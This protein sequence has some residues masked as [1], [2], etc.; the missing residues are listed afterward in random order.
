MDGACSLPEHAPEPA[1]WTR[2]I[3]VHNILRSVKGCAAC[4]VL[5]VNA[6]LKLI[7]CPKCGFVK[8][9]ALVTLTSYTVSR[10]DNVSD[11]D[12]MD[13]LPDVIRNGS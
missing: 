12:S 2:G 5:A 1:V 6:F 11:D 7:H 13:P 4:G 9:G 3:S 8:P 10:D